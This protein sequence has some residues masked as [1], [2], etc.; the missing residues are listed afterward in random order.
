MTMF[1]YD[2]DVLE[3]DPIEEE[4]PE[5]ESQNDD[6]TDSEAAATNESSD[7]NGEAEESSAETCQELR[8]ISFIGGGW[9]CTCYGSCL[10][11][12]YR[13]KS[14]YD[15]DCFYCGHHK[16]DHTPR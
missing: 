15:E 6:S 7:E 9:D 13:P 11:K 14:T 8:P 3:E 16:S 2:D 4:Y 12:Y 10:C 5:Q 1:D